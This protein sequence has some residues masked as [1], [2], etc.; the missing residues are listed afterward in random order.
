MTLTFTRAL[1]AFHRHPCLRLALAFAAIVALALVADQGR[2]KSC[3][4]CKAFAPVPSTFFAAPGSSSSDGKQARPLSC[5][6]D[7]A[8]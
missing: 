8:R 5:R 7:A 4:P 2:A 1:R 6:I 3:V